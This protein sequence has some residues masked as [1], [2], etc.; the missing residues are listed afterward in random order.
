MGRGIL[1]RFRFE[2]LL[3][4]FP[5]LEKCDIMSRFFLRNTYWQHCPVFKNVVACCVFPF[6]ICC[7]H[8]PMFRNVILCRVFSVFKW[9]VAFFFLKH[10]LTS[11]PYVPSFRCTSLDQYFDQGALVG[12]DLGPTE[13]RSFFW[14]GDFRDDLGLWLHPP[15]YSYFLLLRVIYAPRVDP[16]GTGGGTTFPHLEKWDIMLRFFLSNTYWQH[17]PMFKHVVACRVCFCFKNLLP[18]FPYV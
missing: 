8:S 14:K 2:H 4:T 12:G 13:A 10:L 7:Q 17:Y 3:A 6:S 1:P 18:K 9:T 5:H 15:R 16:G 11:F